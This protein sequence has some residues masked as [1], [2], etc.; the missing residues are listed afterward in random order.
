[1]FSVV[2]FKDTD[3]VVNALYVRVYCCGLLA[4]ELCILR[5]KEFH[6]DLHD[7]KGLQGDKSN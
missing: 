2:A 6:L 5:I 7:A 1:L 4:Y 3:I